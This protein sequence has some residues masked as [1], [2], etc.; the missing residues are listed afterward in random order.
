[1]GKRIHC[2]SPVKGNI[3]TAHHAGG[4]NAPQR[5][6]TIMDKLDLC[7]PLIFLSII[8]PGGAPARG[9]TAAPSPPPL[10]AQA[11]ELLQAGKVDAASEV[12]TKLSRVGPAGGQVQY[13]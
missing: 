5:R 1:M 3:L 10:V 6:D 2:L 9:Q 11:Q 4:R 8:P 7:S 12:L 13:L